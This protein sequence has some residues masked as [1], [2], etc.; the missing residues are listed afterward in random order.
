MR[1]PAGVVFF[2]LSSVEATF[3]IRLD[4]QADARPV[5]VPA[6]QV[7]PSYHEHESR[8]DQDACLIAQSQ[9]ESRHGEDGHQTEGC[10]V[11]AADADHGEVSQEREE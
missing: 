1:L 2:L 6:V 9:A 8:P 7:E 3:A 5:V 10:H 11:R 4:P